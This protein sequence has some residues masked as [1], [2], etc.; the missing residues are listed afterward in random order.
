MAFELSPLI[1]W[2]A[3]WIVNTYSAF[4]VNTFS[5]RDITRYYKMSKFLHYANDDPDDVNAKAI[6]MPQLFSENSPGKKDNFIFVHFFSLDLLKR[7]S[8]NDH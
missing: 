1:V 7:Q 4:Q 3:L 8:Q 2:I 6:A 5:N